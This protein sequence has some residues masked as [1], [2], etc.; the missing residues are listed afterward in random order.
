[1]LYVVENYDY[2]SRFCDI[3]DSNAQV[4]NIF[5]SGCDV[6][7]HHLHVCYNFDNNEKYINIIFL[8]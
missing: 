4:P 2:N 5:Q 6:I 1:M 7:N 8:T 3:E